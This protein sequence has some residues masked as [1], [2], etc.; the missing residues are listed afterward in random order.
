MT[1]RHFIGI[2]VTLVMIITLCSMVMAKDPPYKSAWNTAQMSVDGTDFDW[3]DAFPASADKVA[4][5]YAFKNDAN[6]LYVLFKFKDPKQFMSTISWTGMTVYLNASGKKKKD[7][8][9]NFRKKQITADEFIANLEAQQGQLSQEDKDKIRANEFYVDHDVQVSNKKAKSQSLDGVEGIV[10][11]IFRAN[12]SQDET[13]LWEIAIPLARPADMAPG[14]G[15]APGQ[16][17]KVGFQWGGSTDEWKEAMASRMGSQGAQ[18][19]NRARGGLSSESGGASTRLD[20][21][22][23]LASMRRQMPKKYEVWVD[24]VLANQQ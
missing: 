7:Y 17:I 1:K 11:A 19:S 24:V 9:I 10:P 2:L 15:A 21:N 6:F 8:F 16:Q 23:G 18:A 12:Q 14:I 20:S 4:V 3:Q 22:I 5:E 13:Y